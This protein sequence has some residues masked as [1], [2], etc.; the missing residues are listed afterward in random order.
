MSTFRPY[1]VS[2][3]D[4]ANLWPFFDSDTLYL[5]SL[6]DCEHIAA[7]SSPILPGAGPGTGLG[8][9]LDNPLHTAPRTIDPGPRDEAAVADGQ[10][11]KT[12]DPTMTSVV[13]PETSFAEDSHHF[14]NEDCFQQD[15]S[16]SWTCDATTQAPTELDSRLQTPSP[17]PF[18][19]HAE[20]D[21]LTDLH[22]MGAQIGNEVGRN[23]AVTCDANTMTPKERDNGLQII[24]Y[25]HANPNN[26]ANGKAPRGTKSHGK[27]RIRGLASRPDTLSTDPVSISKDS[28]KLFHSNLCT[29][30][31]SVGEER[32]QRFCPRCLPRLWSQQEGTFRI[33]Q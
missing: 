17:D 29:G 33:Q 25:N 27:Q 13:P 32:C 31:E 3:D 24:Q 30:S 7:F 19:P 18:S 26:K 22:R 14:A 10:L 8:A 5:P 16:S 23:S 20:H 4:E 1:N 12:A 21:L 9:A 6:G 28:S 2:T 11:P 15:P